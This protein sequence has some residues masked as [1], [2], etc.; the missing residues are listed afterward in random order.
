MT[1]D[2]IKVIVSMAEVIGKYGIR[3]NRKG[4]IN[5]PFHNEKTASM[6]IYK[7][8]YY[9]FGCGATGDIFTF[10]QDYENLTF[11]EA[12][13]SL[14][15]S[16][17]TS[18]TTSRKAKS[19]VRERDQRIAWQRKEEL[20]MRGIRMYITAYRQIIRTEEPYSDLW[21]YAQDKLPYQLYLLELYSERG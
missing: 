2:E 20:R 1:S 3:I 5:C 10:V 9:C 6:K 13:E 11:Q 16:E 12:L 17:K 15:G 18:F 21:C 7:D 4:F 8:S 14:G 19:A